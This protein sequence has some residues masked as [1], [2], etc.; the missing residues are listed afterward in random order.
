MAYIELGEFNFYKGQ[1]SVTDPCYDD[2]PRLRAKCGVRAG[3]YIGA[4]S[5]KDCGDWGNRIEA[6]AI[7]HEDF[8]SDN[9][10][11][12][13]YTNRIDGIGVDAGL[14]GFFQDKPNYSDDEWN[15]LCSN[16]FFNKDYGMLDC[17]FWCSSGYG[18]GYY[19]V[20][21]A[22]ENEEIVALKIVFIED[23]FEEEDY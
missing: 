9:I 2:E 16:N 1:V 23:E 14:A 4:V 18:D 8:A 11:E 19:D 15:Y 6:I 10:F 20:Y 21:A 13:P 22:Y 5:E 12:L 7:C 17:G 3:S